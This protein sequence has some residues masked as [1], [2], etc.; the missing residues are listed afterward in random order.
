MLLERSASLAAKITEYQKLRSMADEAEQ[1]QTRANQFS[2]LSERIS[3]TRE[4]LGKLASA[5]ITVRFALTDGLGYATKA[6][7]LRAAIQDNPTAINAPPFDLKNDF[8]DRLAGIVVAVELAMTEAWKAHVAKRAD[9]GSN[10]VLSALAQVPQFRSSVTKI[11]PCRTNIAA[12]GNSL[13]PDPKATVARLDALVREHD[14]A[15]SELSAEGIPPS[16]VVFIRAAANEGALLTAYSDEVRTWLER[17]SLLNA[18]R[19]RLR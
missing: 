12:L 7:T 15:W 2:T 16:V 19:I 17:R 5:G 11:R 10:D 14:A 6:R 4:A 13:P 8:T 18:F 1:F 9:F 3:R